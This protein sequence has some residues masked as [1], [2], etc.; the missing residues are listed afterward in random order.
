MADLLKMR[1]GQRRFLR[2][3]DEWR[4]T[5]FV[6]RRQYGK[7]TTFARIAL[8]K[9]MKKRHHTVVFG[10]A[11]LN[12]SREIVRKEA[13]ILQAAI[14]AEM[15]TASSAGGSL[16]IVDSATGKAPDHLTPDDWAG[17]FEA[18]RLEFRYYHSRTIYSRTKVV[19]LR[20]DTVGETG[21]LMPDEIGRINNWRETWEAIEPIVASNPEFR[22]CL[23]TT[24]PPDDTH[25]SFDMLSPPVGMDFRPN[26][27]G[28]L[29]RSDFGIHVLRLDA[30]DAFMDGVP[31]Y[32]LEDGSPLTPEESRR[33]AQDKD[34]WDRN[35]G[36]RFVIGGTG[37]CGLIFLD[38]AQR[39]G[40]GTC[41]HFAISCDADWHAAL[42]WLSEHLGAGNVGVGLDP[43]TTTKA[44]SNPTCLA[45]AEATSAG[46]SFPLIATWKTEDPA[47]TERRV[48]QAADVVAARPAGARARRLTVDATSERYFATTLRRS[49][50]GVL[51]VVLSVGSVSHRSPGY[52][53]MTEKQ[54]L[55]LR[56]IADLED[57]RLALPPERYIRED[58]RL[59]KK[60]RGLLVCEPDQEGRHG[61]TFDG[62][63]LA[64]DSLAGGGPVEIEAAG[65]RRSASGDTGVPA[66]LRDRLG[67]INLDPLRII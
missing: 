16:S 6:A 12:L 2:L 65:Y 28:N 30:W 42:A 18:Q 4:L 1:R 58:W 64:R 44:S 39:R 60:E 55:G 29:Y 38:A 33:R 17:L 3:V 61:D 66:E 34:A 41:R 48:K 32:D 57:N 35:Y 37:A 49:L 56:L 24:P 43:A 47:V 59:L 25:F 27:D 31:V 45:V 22:I 7:T 13:E 21:D 63:K 14:A 5:A 46:T 53:P 62:A 19:A 26:P 51:P 23:S 67:S 20:P 52:E 9:M 10:S 11:K 50:V 15:S 8:K 40:V 54:W 36:C